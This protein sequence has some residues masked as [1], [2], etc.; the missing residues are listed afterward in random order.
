MCDKLCIIC[1]EGLDYE[2]MCGKCSKD[3]N[4]LGFVEAES[5]KQENAKLKAQVEDLNKKLN[6]GVH[7]VEEFYREDEEGN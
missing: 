5:Y 6:P 2:S 7:D 3:I 4:G 1:Q